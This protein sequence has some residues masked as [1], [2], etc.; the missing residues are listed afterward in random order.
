MPGVPICP[1]AR[2]RNSGPC[3]PRPANCHRAGVTCAVNGDVVGGTEGNGLGTDAPVAPGP[4]NED[5]GATGGAAGAGATIDCVGKFGLAVDP[6]GG[7]AGAGGTARLDG[8]PAPG[9][10]G[11]GLGAPGVGGTAAVVGGAAGWVAVVTAI[12]GA[13]VGAGWLSGRNDRCGGTLYCPP[14]EGCFP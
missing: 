6:T 12:A 9:I 3:G 8:A 10:E 14:P 11:D 13:V 7:A 1:V 2:L 5:D 4:P